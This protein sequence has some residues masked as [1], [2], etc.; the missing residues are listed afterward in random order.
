MILVKSRAATAFSIGY[1]DFDKEKAME[2]YWWGPHMFAWMWIFPLSF[3]A[4]CL[5][6]LFAYLCWCPGALGARRVRRELSEA[7]REILDRRYVSGEINAEQYE[8]MKRVLLS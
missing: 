2:P 7:V 1:A 8:E 4:I 3:L 6:F 5:I